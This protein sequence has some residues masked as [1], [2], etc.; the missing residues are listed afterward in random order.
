LAALANCHIH[1]PPNFSAFSSVDEAVEMA[2]NEGVEILGAS[3]YYDF[4]VYE[5]F[6]ELCKQKGIDPLFG[7]EIV[8]WNADYAQRGE[9]I[10]DPANPGKMYLCGK[11]L[12]GLSNPN[13][14]AKQLLNRIREGDALRM[15]AMADKLA[16]CFRRCGLVTDLNACNISETIANRY[17]L[18]IDAVVLQER[19][20]AEAFQASVFA[21]FSPDGSSEWLE[22]LFGNPTLVDVTDPVAVQGEIRTHLMKAGRRAYV[23]E[24]FI[25]FEEAQELIEALGGIVSYPVV[26]D[27]MNP[28]SAFEATPSQLAEN[29]GRLGIGYAEFIPNRN[30]PEVLEEYVDRLVEAG[31]TVTAGTEHNTSDLIAIRP[32]CRKGEAIPAKTDAIFTEGAVAL[33]EWQV[34]AEVKGVV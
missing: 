30:S 33:R 12:R 11:S 19:H 28:R 29:L 3:N 2:A 10:N 31:V 18:P 22:G 21:T 8:C 15:S 23:E 24:S 4:R 26:A 6:A 25:S 13:P 27:G 17:G 7:I 32:K 20:L 5:T 16:D 34:Q 14:R 9:L 1:L